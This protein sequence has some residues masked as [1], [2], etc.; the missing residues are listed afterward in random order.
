M[1]DARAH[2][3]RG[4]QLYTD[5][6]YD[7]ALVELERAN[8]LAPSYKIL[9]SIGL[10]QLR[11]NDFVGAK[12]SFE[13]YLAEGGTEV[14]A[15]RM[16]EV[17]DRLK[18]LAD[19]VASVEVQVNV[20]GAQVFIDDLVVGISPLGKPLLLNPGYHK[21]SASKAGYN[22]DAK[23]L[24]FAGGDKTQ[25]QLHLTEVA[26]A[27]PQAPGPAPAPITVAPPPGATPAPQAPPPAETPRASKPLWI[28][29]TVTGVLAAGAIVT[30]IAAL[31]Q[32]SKLTDE[33]DN[34]PTASSDI[35]STRQKTV[36]LALVTD[37][38]GG[39]AIV[40]GGVTLYLTLSGKKASSTSASGKASGNATEVRVGPTGLSSLGVYGKF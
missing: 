19:R 26:P 24:G 30:G 38:L 21:L 29:W 16:T 1:D 14:P 33:V 22:V 34:Q 6:S 36:T 32:S 8:K 27:S 5:G 40:A 31:S 23:Q 28:G 20:E 35:T 11:L 2:Y 18:Q 15:A 9:Y 3:A 13:R 25:V 12:G 7:A 17:N 4:V 39:A 10:V 37:I